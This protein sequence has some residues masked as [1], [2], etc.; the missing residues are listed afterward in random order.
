MRITYLFLQKRLSIWTAD[1]IFLLFLFFCFSLQVAI[2]PVYN[3]QS[4][5]SHV[6]Y[7]QAYN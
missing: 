1:F 4:F 3:G 2:K 7:C 5:L 6:K